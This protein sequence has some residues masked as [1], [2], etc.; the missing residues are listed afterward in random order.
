MPLASQIAIKR[1]VG[2]REGRIVFFKESAE[3]VVHVRILGRPPGQAARR[4]FH[5]AAEYEGHAVWFVPAISRGGWVVGADYVP[6]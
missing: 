6:T 4:V 5:V 2:V 1:N 3:F